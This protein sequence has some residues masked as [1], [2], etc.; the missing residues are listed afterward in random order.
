[1]ARVEGQDKSRQ[2]AR[3]SNITSCLKCRLK[4]RDE[5]RTEIKEEKA[6][7]Q[8]TERDSG[9]EREGKKQAKGRTEMYGFIFTLHL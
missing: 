9:E 8:T 5:S 4:A 3:L 2:T 7:K 1:M 6:D